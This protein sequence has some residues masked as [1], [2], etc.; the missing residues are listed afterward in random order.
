M[1]KLNLEFRL[2]QLGVKK[3]MYIKTP[4]L[5]V[6]NLKYYGKII[7]PIIR[8][9]TD[10]CIVIQITKMFQYFTREFVDKPLSVSSQNVFST[11][12]LDQLE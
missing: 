1:H 9:V 12:L 6:K 3:R 2:I 10:E 7:I 8:S 11:K 5:I 4:L